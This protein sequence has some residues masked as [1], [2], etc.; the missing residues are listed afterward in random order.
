MKRRSGFFKASQR[1]LGFY[2]LQN[3]M[4]A[5]TLYQ[6]WA[7]RRVTYVLQNLWSGVI[8][9]IHSRGPGENQELIQLFQITLKT[10]LHTP[11]T[12]PS[13]LPWLQHGSTSKLWNSLQLSA[14][15]PHTTDDSWFN[16]SR[17]NIKCQPTVIWCVCSIQTSQIKFLVSCLNPQE[18]CLH[19]CLSCYQD[20][21]VPDSHIQRLCL[22]GISS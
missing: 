21:T 10:S 1:Y 9:L 12:M 6:L 11:V 16:T 2:I 13:F 5:Q 20:F 4:R 19:L 8:A 17:V 14:G 3:C 18:L 15:N 7:V 22:Q